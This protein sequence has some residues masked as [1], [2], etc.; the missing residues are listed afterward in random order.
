MNEISA[1]VKETPEC[2][3]TPCAMGRYS[4]KTAVYEPGSGLSSDSESAGALI[5]DFIS[6]RTVIK[7]YFF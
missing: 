5:L 1:L 3:L 6:F 7:K 4:K 2:F